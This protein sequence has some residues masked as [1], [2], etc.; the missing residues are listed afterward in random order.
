MYELEEQKELATN[1]LTELEK[2]S[3]EHQEALT[4]IEKLKMDVSYMYLTS[5]YRDKRTI[6]AWTRKLHQTE[7]LV[8]ITFF[9]QD[10]ASFIMFVASTPA[11]KYNYGHHW[12]QMPA[13]PVFCAL[14][15]QHADP[16]TAGWHPELTPDQQKHTSQASGA[17][18]SNCFNNNLY[19]DCIV[20]VN[21]LSDV[22]NV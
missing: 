17:T 5:L 19:M 13:V 10:W 8:E 12:V 21:R 7:N 2:L 15:W 3:K 16:D 18:W 4:E 11:R 6:F 9:C 22:T 14:Q 1:R 20:I